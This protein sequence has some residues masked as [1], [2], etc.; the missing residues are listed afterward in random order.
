[1][2]SYNLISYI[3]SS[4]LSSRVPLPHFP[5]TPKAFVTSN[6]TALEKEQDT[7]KWFIDSSFD[8]QMMH[9]LGPILLKPS[10]M[11]LDSRSRF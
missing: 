2:C 1:M 4:M 10:I 8:L 7:S 9:L 5:F 6:H 3:H 11:V